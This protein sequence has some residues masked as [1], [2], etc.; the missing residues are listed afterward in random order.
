MTKMTKLVGG[1]AELL[2]ISFGFLTVASLFAVEGTGPDA[3]TPGNSIDAVYAI[4]IS[5]GMTSAAGFLRI[6]SFL[7]RVPV[8][9]VLGQVLLPPFL[10]WLSILAAIWISAFGDVLITSIGRQSGLIQ[11]LGIA[12]LSF[13]AWLLALR[14]ERRMVANVVPWLPVA[15]CAFISSIFA[16]YFGPQE[17]N[18]IAAAGCVAGGFAVYLVARKVAS[19]VKYMAIGVPAVAAIAVGWMILDAHRGEL[20]GRP[21]AVDDG[22][23][24]VRGKFWQ[25]CFLEDEGARVRCYIWTRRGD[26]VF[27]DVFLPFDD[28][29]TPDAADLSISQHNRNPE[30]LVFLEN[31]RILLPRS[32]F[33]EM[34]A[35]VEEHWV[36]H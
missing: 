8:L 19:E 7:P 21:H 33:E 5:F 34:K 1:I 3:T 20:V 31:G 16:I 9:G 14:Y 17:V 4:E 27:D 36:S 35:F 10:G 23:V 15:T 30:R 24:M 22:A 29:P 32:R 18:R 11:S 2:A 25:Q 12:M 28:G 6:S 26:L 13:G